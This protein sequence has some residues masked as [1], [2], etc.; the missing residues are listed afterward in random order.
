MFRAAGLARA[1][2]S[3]SVSGATAAPLTMQRMVFHCEALASQRMQHPELFFTDIR[4]LR[5]FR[6]QG[7][8][9]VAAFIRDCYK[10]EQPQLK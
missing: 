7:P 5:T 1:A 8:I 10:L 2:S 9:A 3:A 6:R 4:D